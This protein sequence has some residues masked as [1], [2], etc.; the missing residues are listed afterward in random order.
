MA[1]T[2]KPVDSVELAR[3]MRNKD[4]EDGIV[5]SYLQ[6]KKRG[7]TEL[8]CEALRAYYLPFALSAAGVSGVELQSAL[9]D[10][11]AQLE[12]QIVKMKRTFGMEGLPQVVLVNPHS[13][14]FSQGAIDLEPTIGTNGVEIAPISAN[15]VPPSVSFFDSTGPSP[16]L[17]PV[18]SEPARSNILEQDSEDDG[19]FNDDEDDPIAKAE[20]EVDAGFHL[21]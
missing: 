6:S 13:G 2:S 10:A 4:T 5:I 12:V 3:I 11:I 15:L 21:A 14:V 1:R 7:Q 17:L 18:I 9:H 16:D 20:I 8:V 19:F